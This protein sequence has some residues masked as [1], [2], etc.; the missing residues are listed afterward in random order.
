MRGDA[1]E[2]SIRRMKLDIAGRDM[3]RL[4]VLTIVALLPFLAVAGSAASARRSYAPS[5][6][7]PRIRP[8]NVVFAC[9]D[10]GYYATHLSWSI[11]HL[12]HATGEGLFHQN[13]CD[14]N[15]AG[16][17][18]QNSRGRIVLRRRTWCGGFNRFVFT[19]VT[20]VYRRPLLG[21]R[22]TSFKMPLPG[23]CG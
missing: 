11:W 9:A 5:C 1:A 23:R 13:D 16:G 20:V 14:P 4:V 15:C 17:T 22:R 6:K 2:R 19:R 8:T 10:H 12:Q 18:F 7:R 3:R 21:R